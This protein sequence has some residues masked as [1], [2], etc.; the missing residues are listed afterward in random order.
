MSWWRVDH[1][2]AEV[3]IARTDCEKY[4]DRVESL[5]GTRTLLESEWKAIYIGLR[6]VVIEN[7]AKGNALMRLYQHIVQRHSRHRD[8]E[9]VLPEVSLPPELES[10]EPPPLRLMD[11]TDQVKEM[12][13]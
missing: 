8:I 3:R 5:S 10:P 2:L 12:H 1:G 7:I 4:A 9:M 11:V 13:Q 6:K